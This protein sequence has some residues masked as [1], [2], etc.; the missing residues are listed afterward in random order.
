MTARISKNPGAGLADPSGTI[1]DTS[2][3]PPFAPEIRRKSKRACCPSQLRRQTCGTT[4]FRSRCSACLIARQSA[5]CISVIAPEIGRLTATQRGVPPN[6]IPAGSRLNDPNRA[7]AMEGLSFV[8]AVLWIGSRLADGLAHA[9]DR[10]AFVGQQKG[11]TLAAMSNKCGPS[12]ASVHSMDPD[13][14][15]DT[16][17]A[18]QNSAD[19]PTNDHEKNSNSQVPFP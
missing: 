1:F 5:G 2:P 9:H 10:L 12:N 8:Q 15:P 19:P 16:Q 3:A 13:T 17:G 4:L 18:K 11:E 6:A 7:P 14:P